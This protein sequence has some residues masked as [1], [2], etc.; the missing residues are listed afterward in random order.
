MR[1][2][3][4]QFL[5]TVVFLLMKLAL[6]SSKRMCCVRCQIVLKNYRCFWQKVINTYYNDNCRKFIQF[7]TIRNSLPLIGWAEY[8]IQSKD[9]VRA[10]LLNFLPAYQ[11]VANFV[12]R[13]EKENRK[14]LTDA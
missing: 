1:I 4:L 9:F 10:E 3:T 7:Y 2:Y 13:A 12:F 11:A 8:Q 6:D 5:Y 14:L